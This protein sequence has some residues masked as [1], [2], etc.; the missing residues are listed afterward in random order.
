MYFT[1]EPLY[2]FGYGLSYTSFAYPNLRLNSD[3]L[4]AKGSVTVSVDVR[5][6]GTRAGEEVVQMYVKHLNSSVARPVKE[7][8]GF[9]RILLQPA[10][11]K[12][13]TMPLTAEQLAYWDAGKHSFV[14]ENDKAQ[15][16]VGSSSASQKLNRT[17]RV[18]R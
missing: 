9:A 14:V 1:G 10:Q 7:L 2:P 11:I 18:V 15:I 5:N 6:T 16:M 8:K 12:T 13:V 3:S 4:P 17:I